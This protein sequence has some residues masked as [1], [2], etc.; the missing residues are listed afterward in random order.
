MSAFTFGT[1]QG[2]FG[3]WSGTLVTREPLVHLDAARGDGEGNSAPFRRLAFLHGGRRHEVPVVSGNSIRGVWRRLLAGDLLARLDLAVQDLGPR[4]IYLLTSGG[5]LEARDR[6]GRPRA[7]DGPPPPPEPV[8]RIGSKAELR[9]RLPMLGLLG[10]AYGNAL[11]EGCLR[12]GH[13]IPL[14]A[15]TA[16]AL[17]RESAVAVA[18]LTGWTF[19]TRRDDRLAEGASPGQ[20]AAQQQIYRFEYLL[21]GVTLCHSFGV[22]AAAALEV[23]CLA[24]ALD[25]FRARPYLGGRWGAGSG[26]VAVDY[27]AAGDPRPYREWVQAHRQEVRAYLAGLEPRSGR[28]AG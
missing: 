11:L 6:P 7:G 21:P 1:G 28:K 20:R 4:V 2:E 8:L 5:G 3:S 17:G 16:P 22:E 25:L 24:H 10:A 14:C 18:D 19:H 12:V 26:Q 15:V 23:S 13:A 9:S 27:P